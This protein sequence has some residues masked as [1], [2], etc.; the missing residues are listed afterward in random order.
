[1]LNDG[2]CC[3]LAMLLLSH[4]FPY[5]PA[6]PH[7]FPLPAQLRLHCCLLC[8]QA[9]LLR[10]QLLL[11]PGLQLCCLGITTRQQ[12]LVLTAAA[13]A[14]ARQQERRSSRSQGQT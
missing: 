4:P 3:L 9:C 7:H 11:Q 10:Q 5:V 1:M 8:L 6:A 12:H 13:H 14:A 2:P